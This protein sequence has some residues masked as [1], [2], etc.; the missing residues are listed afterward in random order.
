MQ[1]NYNKK[2]KLNKLKASLLLLMMALFAI[3]AQ[4][5]TRANEIRMKTGTETITDEV[6]YDF[7]DTGGPYIMDP[8]LDPGNNYNWV[9]WYQH[10]ESYLLH[11]INPK[12]SDGKGILVN[13]NYL[14]I[15]NDYLRIYE[16]DL[17][18]P[19]NLIAELTCNDFSTNNYA[20]FTV[21]SHGNMTIRFESDY[22]WRD[23]GWAAKVY[24]WDYQ[25]QPPV[26]NM[27]A[28]ASYIQL[29]PGSKAAGTNGETK[30]Y[31]NINNENEPDPG[32]PTTG[33]IEYTAPFQLIAAPATV[34]VVLTENGVASR[35]ATYTFSHLITPPNPPTI[36]HVAGTN[37]VI[38]K[39]PA[40]PS[41][42]NDTYYVQYSLDNTDPRYS[43]HDVVKADTIDL[44]EPCTIRAV[45]HGTTC[46]NIFSTEVTETIST[47]YVP[48]PVIDVTG[49]NGPGSGTITCSLA[50]A[51]IYYTMDGTEP[52]TSSINHGTSP[53]NLSNV[54][55]GTTI[56]AMAHMDG[57]GY[58]NS[59][60]A[61]FVYL[62]DNAQGGGG[63][64]GDVVL[65]DDREDHRWR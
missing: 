29:T 27:Q 52:T 11:L 54:P 2:R 43:T 40:V 26:A 6:E 64:F 21:M 45:T 56:K 25:R 24:L 55:A 36:T 9:T 53:I 14:L 60:V 61:T 38:I 42:Q 19:E 37:T 8:S 15:N 5:Q 7:Y 51:T 33:V 49:T 58:Q 16:G 4:A 22:H 59:V 50:D 13:F 48:T 18:S 31:Y 10:N 62:P 1:Q 47:I 35:V 32:D 57:E 12:A 3:P 30:M 63:V 23:A 65:L 17:E 39:A 34:K 46:P 28:C 20:G 44:L 41:D